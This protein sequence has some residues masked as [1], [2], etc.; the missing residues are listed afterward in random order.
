MAPSEMPPAVRVLNTPPEDADALLGAWLTAPNVV[1]VKLVA[2]ITLSDTELCAPPAL[3]DADAP[4]PERSSAGPPDGPVI[5]PVLM[6]L[7]PLTTGGE[8]TV[9]TKP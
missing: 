7:P 3:T 5:S 8:A 4:M 6:M 2:P 9:T 1:P